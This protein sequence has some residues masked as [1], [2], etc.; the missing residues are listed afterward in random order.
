MTSTTA[1]PDSLE[2][3]AIRAVAAFECFKGVVVILAATG[4]LALVH[5]NLHELAA[6]F[7]E[8]L[9]LDPAA[10][11]PQ[12]FLDAVNRIQDM[13]LWTLALGAGAYAAVRFV[14]AYGLF[15]GRSWAE[16]LAAGSGGIYI[17]FEVIE[18]VRQ[19][20]WWGAAF[21]VVNVLVVAVMVRAL[22]QRRSSPVSSI[23]KVTVKK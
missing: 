3:K 18:F 17:P 2:R 1:R 10:R 6:R 14:E 5:Q 11:Y 15:F 22:R 23:Y 9:H 20:S 13:R 12:I 21:F 8:H 4:V 16:W 19:P 7:V